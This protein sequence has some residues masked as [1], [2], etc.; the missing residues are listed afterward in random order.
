MATISANKTSWLKLVD[1][2]GNQIKVC[3]QS[4]DM[5]RYT[6]PTMQNAQTRIVRLIPSVPRRITRGFRLYYHYRQNS[7]V[8]F[9]VWEKGRRMKARAF[10]PFSS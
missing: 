2:D 8:A 5:E 9:T 10:S 7:V 1:R 3:L 6:A 4:P